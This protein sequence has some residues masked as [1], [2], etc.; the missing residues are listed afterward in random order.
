ME[1]RSLIIGYLLGL[2]INSQ[3]GE[4]KEFDASF[5]NGILYIRK[6]PAELINFLLEVD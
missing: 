3:M 1:E 4:I 5:E 6:A 2:M